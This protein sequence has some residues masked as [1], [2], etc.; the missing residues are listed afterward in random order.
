MANQSLYKGLALALV[1]ELVALVLT[2][3]ANKSKRIFVVNS[4]NQVVSKAYN[5]VF[6]LNNYFY[7]KTENKKLIKSNQEFLTKQ[8]NC[9]RLRDTI[10]SLVY[11]DVVKNSINR[12]NN[13][14]IISAGANQGIKPG[15]GVISDN[16]TIVGTV[17]AVGKNYSSVLS[18]LNQ[19][20]SISVLHKK[21]KTLGELSWADVTSPI[22]MIL[23]DIPTYIPVS[24]GDTIITSGYS[25]IWPKGLFV[26]TVYSV[27]KSKTAYRYKIKVRLAS[28]MSRLQHVFVIKN[29]DKPEIEKVLAQAQKIIK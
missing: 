21:S 17:L 24:V 11:A 10:Y 28:D 25:L 22:F 20:S 6:S 3:S 1:L 7:L 15:D 19:M 27:K 26:G 14:L 23:D 29:R 4:I 8:F 12:A 2:V 9:K 13:L 18:I 5:Y 16:G